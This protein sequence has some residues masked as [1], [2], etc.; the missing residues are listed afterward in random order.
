MK[1]NLTVGEASFL[2]WLE[3]A[4]PNFY[5]YAM[6]Q[7]NNRLSAPPPEGTVVTSSLLDDLSTLA[8]GFFEYK[9]QKDIFDNQL[10]VAQQNQQVDEFYRQLEYQQLTTPWYKSFRVDPMMGGIA[11]VALLGLWWFAR[12][13]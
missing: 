5:H 7:L 10:D 6:T 3:R 8:S 11:I 9:L 1:N 12:R 4:N 2:R 13:Q